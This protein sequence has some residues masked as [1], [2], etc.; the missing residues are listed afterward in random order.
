[1][2]LQKEKIK[3]SEI[4]WLFVIGCL[5]GFVLETIWHFLKNGVW[6][7]K[8]GL[9][10]GPFKPIYGFGLIF[11]VLI[12]NNYRE[13]KFWQKFI[14]GIILGS[15]FEYFGSLFQEYVF[16][17]S[18]WNYSNFNLNIGGRIYLPYC[19]AWGIIAVF[20]V[21]FVYPFL[22]KILNKINPCFYK[23]ITV[24]VGIFMII[25]I[26]LTALASIRYSDRANKENTDSAVF[27]VIDS[28]YPDEYMQIKFPKMKIIKS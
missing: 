11:I 9:L 8:Q 25:N 20:C 27:K 21:D 2:R 7:N 18:T 19:F 6:I 26:S 3:I 28:L 14:I 17:T 1:M 12:M 22:K 24:G 5:V 13:K 15:A 16:G 23:I 10:Y 4:I